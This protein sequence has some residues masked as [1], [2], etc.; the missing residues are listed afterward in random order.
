MSLTSYRAA[1][2]RVGVVWVS[3]DPAWWPGGDRLSRVLRR[4][5]MGAGVFHGRVRDGNGCINPAMATGPPG[6]IL[7]YGWDDL[8]VSAWFGAVRGGCVCIRAV[9]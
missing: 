2:P 3:E 9:V 8:G 5:T 4:S 1:P 7:G 6:R